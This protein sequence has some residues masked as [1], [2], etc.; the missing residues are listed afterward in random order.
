MKDGEGVQGSR[1][2]FYLY[3]I[4]SLRIAYKGNVTSLFHLSEFW[5]VFKKLRLEHDFNTFLLI[6]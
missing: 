2:E 5:I 3:S 6:F 4:K 1:L